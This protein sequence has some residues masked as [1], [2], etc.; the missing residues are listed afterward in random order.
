[1]KTNTPQWVELLGRL[2]GTWTIEASHPAMPGMVVS[3]TVNIEWLE[4]A[5]FLIHRARVEHDDFPDSISI[6]GVTD[7]DRAEGASESD[8]EPRLSMHYFDSRGVFRVY[9]ASIDDA[10]WRMW[11]DAPGFSQRFAGTFADEN[12]TIAG[13]WQLC[14]DDKTWQDDLKITYRRRR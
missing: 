6:I 7:H 11:R 5:R 13:A 10:A 2:V 14:T 12:D 8:D 4:G 9:A 3:G 1:M